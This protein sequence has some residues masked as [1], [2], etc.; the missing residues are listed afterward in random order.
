MANDLTELEKELISGWMNETAEEKE[1][2]LN[3]YNY[4]ASLKHARNEWLD[5]KL[6]TVVGLDEFVLE[7]YGIQMHMDSHGNITPQ[8]EIADDHKYLIFK[9]KFTK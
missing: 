3:K 2:R 1:N 5:L 8:H 9:L 4:W 7:Q 6:Q